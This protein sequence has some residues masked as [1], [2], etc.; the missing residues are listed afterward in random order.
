MFRPLASFGFAI[1]G[2]ALSAT[3][4]QAATCESLA[5]LALPWWFRRP[6]GVLPRRRDAQA[7]LRLRH[8]DRGLAASEQLERQIPGGRQRRVERQYR[9][10]CPGHRAASWLRRRD[11]RYR[12]RRRWR[13][14]DGQPGEA[15]RLRLSRRA[16]DDREGQGDDQRLLRQCAAALL[17]P[18]LLRRRP[19]GPQG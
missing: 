7:D 5:S 16:R 10:Q 14:V 1:A 17:L 2:L 12:P 4:T 19:P 15:R 18:G 9:S 3:T 6:A 11:H 13:S 8:Q